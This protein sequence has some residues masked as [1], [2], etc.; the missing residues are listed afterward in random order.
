MIVP[1]SK[2]K[3]ELFILEQNFLFF[4]RICIPEA[5]LTADIIL[6]TL[7]NISEGLVVYPKV[8]DKINFS[9]EYF[10]FRLLTSILNKNYHL[11]LLK[12]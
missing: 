11:W 12:I 6:F 4:R 7:Q 3:T 2:T 10:R 9:S 1:I 5:F 8:K